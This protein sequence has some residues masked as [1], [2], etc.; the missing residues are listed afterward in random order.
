[1]NMSGNAQLNGLTGKVKIA[2]KIID[3][4]PARTLYATVQYTPEGNYVAC[5]SALPNAD[6]IPFFQE[7][8]LAVNGRGEGV[9]TLGDLCED[10][11]ISGDLEC[12]YDS[13]PKRWDGVPHLIELWSPHALRKH[14]EA[15]LLEDPETNGPRCFWT[16]P[17]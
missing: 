8:E 5:L 14:A 9:I 10:A 2:K 12:L 17:A 11:G 13:A 3:F 7:R 4:L 15:Q 1:M 16:K 6:A